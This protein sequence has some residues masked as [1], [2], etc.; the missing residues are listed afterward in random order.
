MFGRPHR[1]RPKISPMRRPTRGAV[2]GPMGGP[3]RRPMGGPNNQPMSDICASP[4][5]PAHCPSIIT[6]KNHY[7]RDI[8][9]LADICTRLPHLPRC[10]AASNASPAGSGGSG[11]FPQANNKYKLGI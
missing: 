8:R 11:D 1:G 7:D 9:P 6:E 5:P 3:M 10:Q 2:S 4:N